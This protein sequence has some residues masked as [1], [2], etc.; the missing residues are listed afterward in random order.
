MKVISF[1]V[2]SDASRSASWQRRRDR[3][4]ELLSRPDGDL[5][6]LQEPSLGMVRDLQERMPEYSWVGHGRD[7]GGG[8][9][10]FTPIFFRKDRFRVIESASFWLSAACDVPGRGWDAYC[11]RAQ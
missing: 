10:E 7:D 11:S 6:G 5:L 1:N 3:M 9:G 2:W 8:L 4:A